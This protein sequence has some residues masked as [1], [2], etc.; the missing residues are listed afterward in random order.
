MGFELGVWVAE[1]PGY[2]LL[3]ALALPLVLVAWSELRGGSPSGAPTPTA[4][5]APPPAT[6]A[7]AVPAGEAVTA[8]PE[9]AAAPQPLPPEAKPIPVEPE[10]APEVAKPVAPPVGLRDRLSR[11]SDALVGRLGELLGG[12]NLDADLLDELEMLLFGA[13]LGVKTAESLLEQVRSE[14][15]GKSAEEVR[16]ILKSAIL[17]KLRKVEPSKGLAL[18]A[19]P[20][21]I[22]VLGV[23][24]AGK[25][26]TIGKLGARYAA[27]GHQVLLGAAD[28]FRA[29]AIEQ[30]QVWGER[31]G[32][33]VIAGVQGGDPSA[34]AFDT[35]KAARSRDA[36]VVIIDTAGRLQTKKPLMEELGKM[37]RVIGREIDGAPHETLLVLDSNTGQNAISQASLFT[38]VAPVTGLVLTKLDGTAKGGVIVGLADEFGI[39]VKHVGVGETIEDLRDFD[40]E[41]FVDALFNDDA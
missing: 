3:L 12:R 30:L 9:R 28:T 2:A 21:V 14:G 8:T 10:P 34:V 35:V 26:T 38:E 6:S 37:S 20:H 4:P 25:T 33:E 22:L 32:C 29:A 40:A 19:K 23:N 27:L 11:T 1:N 7:G 41:E 31:V 18:D 39:P 16:F 5:E 36:D 17:D 24:G 13:D 15:S